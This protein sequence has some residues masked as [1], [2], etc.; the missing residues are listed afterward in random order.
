MTD[1]ELIAILRSHENWLNKNGG[2]RA[3]LHGADL[4]GTDLRRADLRRADLR[5]SD[6]SGSNLGNADLRYSDL[7]YSDLR[8]SNLGNAD[9]CDSDLRYSDLRGSNLS[10]VD[11]RWTNLIEANLSGSDM[12]GATLPDFQICPEEGDFV[13]WKSTR[14]GVVK[15][16]IPADSKRTSSLVGRKCRAEYA[17]VLEG[18]GRSMYDPDVEYRPGE[19]VHP[20]KYCD[21]IRLECSHG[22]HFFMTQREAE[23]WRG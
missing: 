17:V 22:I 4:C 20:D 23:R 16:L 6:L 1:E 7:R 9:L 19:K 12:T 11:L 18:S 10:G 2:E 5:D 13:A 8:G 3:N 21:D 15:L 14:G